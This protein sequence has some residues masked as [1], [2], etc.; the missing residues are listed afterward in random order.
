MHVTIHAEN[1]MA[2]LVTF[3]HSFMP[4]HQAMPCIGSAPR[5]LLEADLETSSATHNS[6]LVV[7]HAHVQIHSASLLMQKQ[8]NDLAHHCVYVY[9]L[10]ATEATNLATFLLSRTR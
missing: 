5:L 2:H 10:Q 6:S 3:I 4:Q 7:V 1:G 8:G 9:E